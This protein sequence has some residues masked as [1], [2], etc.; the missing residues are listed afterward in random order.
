MALPYMLRYD[1]EACAAAVITECCYCSAAVS[2]QYCACC[3]HAAITT[4]QKGSRGSRSTQHRQ[5][6]HRRSR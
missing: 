4:L 5:Q 2:T 1:L 6:L 3:N